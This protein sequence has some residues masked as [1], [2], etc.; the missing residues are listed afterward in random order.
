MAAPISN[1][2]NLQHGLR[3]LVRGRLPA[4]G[5]YIAATVRLLEQQIEAAVV[6]ARRSVSIADAALIHTAGRWERHAMLCQR[7]L[8]VNENL[9][10]EQQLKFSREICMASERRDA[11]IRA[12]GIGAG[13]DPANP[14]SVIPPAA[15]PAPHSSRDAAGKGIDWDAVPPP[16]RP[17]DGQGE[18]SSERGSE[19]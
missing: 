19:A 18:A 15:L 2:N 7:W 16:P 14:W 17:A 3:S 9:T 10:P 11:A 6:Q 1:R 4:G 8:R 12:L 13:A 5:T